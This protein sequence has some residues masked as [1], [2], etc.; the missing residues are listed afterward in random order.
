M[1]PEDSEGNT[2]SSKF[3]AIQWNLVEKILLPL[4]TPNLMVEWRDQIPVLQVRYYK[5]LKLSNK[6]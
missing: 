2:E 1:L 6:F 4:H 3:G 5:C